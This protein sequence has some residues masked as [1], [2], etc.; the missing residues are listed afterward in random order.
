MREPEVDR[1]VGATV[2]TVAALG[3]VVD[4]AIVLHNSNKLALRLLPCDVFARV[5][6][7]GQ[8]VAR[9]EVELA[10]RLAATGS[11]VTALDPR[12]APRVHER[13]G[14]ALTLWPYYEPLPSDVAPADYADALA[15]L[16]A[17]MRTIGIGAPH[18][19]DRVADARQLVATCD[20]TAVLPDEDR[21][22]LGDTLRDSLR[23]IGE[24]GAAE[25]L[26]HGEP[27]SGN[28]LGTKQGLRFVDL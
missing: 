6:P 21:D 12:V 2:M 13:D 19:T 7:V 10:Q 9:F 28:V 15:R 5:A 16:H 8:E 1:A 22:L 3:L 26:L 25:Q 18:F 4:E 27:Y 24:R 20:R 14:F 11:P 17:G 23:A